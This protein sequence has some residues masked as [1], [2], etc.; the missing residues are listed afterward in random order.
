[1]QTSSGQLAKAVMIMASLWFPF[2]FSLF[3]AFAQSAPI[4]TLLLEPILPA[5]PCTQKC[6]QACS[7]AECLSQCQTLQ[8]AEGNSAVV[9]YFLLVVS[10]MGAIAVVNE[11]FYSK[12][13]KEKMKRKSRRDNYSH[14]SSL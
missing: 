12:E 4:Q 9:L 1:M 8:C 5:A 7:S 14:Y 10:S 6:L 11:V 3:L 13:L 2:L